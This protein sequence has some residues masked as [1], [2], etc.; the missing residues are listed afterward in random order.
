VPMAD[1]NLYVKSLV[2]EHATDALLAHLHMLSGGK[3]QL[4]RYL[5]TQDLQSLNIAPLAARFIV[6]KLAQAAGT[7]DAALLADH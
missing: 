3:E 1:F 4:L 7:N 5:T 6:E 2:G